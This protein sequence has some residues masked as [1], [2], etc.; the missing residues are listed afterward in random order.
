MLKSNSVF[1]DIYILRNSGIK[2][3]AGC[4]GST[5][6]KSHVE[7]HDLHTGFL[8]AINSF[9]KETFATSNL[10]TI[11]YDDVQVNFL[12]DSKNGLIFVFIH[13]INVSKDEIQEQLLKTSQKFA[14]KYKDILKNDF[15]DDNSFLGF[16]QELISM[17]ILSEDIRA[18][19]AGI[20]DVKTQK[21]EKKRRFW[22]I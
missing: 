6:C 15:I 3:L 8:A 9:S 4:T 7:S 12:N 18:I 11:L 13:P 5:F 17:G 21:K 16:E 19:M 20:Q 10:R 22:Q 2:L 14:E 1:Y